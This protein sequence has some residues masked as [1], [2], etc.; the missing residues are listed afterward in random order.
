MLWPQMSG[1][2]AGAQAG[3]GSSKKACLNS[4][5]SINRGPN[6]TQHRKYMGGARQGS[7]EPMNL[8]AFYDHAA[9]CTVYTTLYDYTTVVITILYHCMT[10]KDCVTLTPNP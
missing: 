2:V 4:A 3:S 6:Y 1:F 7:K 9:Y 5:S 10:I 8:A